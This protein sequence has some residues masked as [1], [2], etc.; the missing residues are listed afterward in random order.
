MDLTTTTAEVSERLL[1]DGTAR[2]ANFYSWFAVPDMAVTKAC[3][4]ART[5]GR[6]TPDACDQ[7]QIV[8]GYVKYPSKAYEDLLQLQ[9][10]SSWRLQAAQEGM[11]SASAPTQQ[12]IDFVLGLAAHLPG[13]ANI[14]IECMR[15]DFQ[16]LAVAAQAKKGWYAGDA[17]AVLALNPTAV[18]EVG[19]DADS[20]QTA[21]ASSAAAGSNQRR[22]LIDKGRKYD[23]HVYAYRYI[24]RLYSLKYGQATED[25]E[26]EFNTFQQ[27]ALTEEAFASELQRRAAALIHR[28]DLNERSLIMR[29][30]NGLTDKTLAADLLQVLQNATTTVTMSDV[31]NRVA[32]YKDTMKELATVRVQAEAAKALQQQR[33]GF[34]RAQLFAKHG[35]G[36]VADGSSSSMAPK[37]QMLAAARA[38]VQSGQ[39]APEHDLAPCILRGHSSHL[40]FECQSSAHP[41]NRQA[42]AAGSSQPAGGAYMQPFSRGHTLPAGAA[43]MQGDSSKGMGAKSQ[44]WW[45][46]DSAKG[47]IA[48][49]GGGYRPNYGQAGDSSSGGQRCDLCH[50]R[51]HSADRCFYAHPDKAPPGWK[52][53]KE[54]RAEAYIVYMQKQQA[55]P[56]AAGAAIE[57]PEQQPQ[58]SASGCVYDQSLDWHLGGGAVL[59]CSSTVA[60]AAM[61]G[62]QPHGFWSTD[63]G[64]QQGSSADKGSSSSGSRQVNARLTAAPGAGGVHVQ[65]DLMLPPDKLPDLLALAGITSGPTQ[66]PASAKEQQTAANTNA[67]GEAAG[68]CEA[69]Q[70]AGAVGAVL[71]QVQSHL[72]LDPDEINQ[73]LRSYNAECEEQS[74]YTFIGNTWETGVTA[75]I[76]DRNV[77]IPRAVQDGG[78]IPNLMSK[79]FA[80]AVGIHYSPGAP[81]VKNIE[82]Q[83][84]T[85]M[86]WTT[87]PLQIVLAQGTAGEV[88]LDVPDGFTVVDSDEAADMYDVVLGRKLLAQVSG[89]VLPFSRMFVYMPRL[90]QG[91]VTTCT[92]PIKVGRSRQATKGGLVDAA[93]ACD[94]PCSFYMACACVQEPEPLQAQ[95]PDTTGAAAAA[96]E[97]AGPQGVADRAAGGK[98]SG[99]AAA[100]HRGCRLLT[101][102]GLFLLLLWPVMWLFSALDDFCVNVLE[103]RPYQE[104]G[105]IF[106]RLG[107]YHRASDGE[108]IKLRCAPGHSGNKPKMI[109]LYR[110]VITWEFVRCTLT[111]RIALLLSLLFFFCISGTTAMQA[112]GHV[113]SALHSPGL[114]ANLL[115]LLPLPT[116]TP[117]QML[118]LGVA[119]QWGCT[120]RL[121]GGP[122]HA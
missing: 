58:Q 45:H 11:F 51:N 81:G 20:T 42:A 26:A 85:R 15:K 61:R 24:T 82:G 12:E 32:Q 27:G 52:P 57:A 113:A 102:K 44:H 75:R 78:C 5:A 21:G 106:Y 30:V 4:N 23:P 16:S 103:P 71:T 41:R 65:V 98:Q 108:Q 68:G 19:P 91:D 120:F 105:K 50:Q 55:Q 74:M 67:A 17:A 62:A 93:A 79:R 56:N 100:Q 112:A 72:D 54:V 95:R 40:N 64:P 116:V 99:S 66:A 39:Y 90:Q 111:S 36:P 49:A 110:R 101:D 28:T 10:V 80:D 53:S 119:E 121:L 48:Q 63:P 8:L 9:E 118:L 86:N 87:Q 69:P 34:D 94:V 46:Q 77:L 70:A 76:G 73:Q 115:P 117:S 37:K 29:F 43:A 83:R 60:G 109:A 88:V 3:T 47:K 25:Q 14:I 35:S 38:M 1:F 89:F 2:G 96:W 84:S 22:V 31:L 18:V 114:T 104:E 7:L 59:D 92:L 33:V 97:P 107:R 122:T 13:K 6:Q